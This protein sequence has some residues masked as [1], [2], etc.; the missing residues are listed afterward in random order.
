MVNCQN[1]FCVY[2]SKGECVLKEVS[3]DISGAC[4]EC[5][6]VAIDNK[7]LQKEKSNILKNL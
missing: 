5:I 4:E 3:I 1:I 2:E 6:Y 7:V